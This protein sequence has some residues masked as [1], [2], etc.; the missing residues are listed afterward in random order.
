MDEKD[1]GYNTY[2]NTNTAGSN[3]VGVAEPTSRV[4]ENLSG[5]KDKVSEQAA[6]LKGKITDQAKT[7]GSQLTQKIDNARGKTSA[8]LRSTSD[9]IN[10]LAMYVE[11]HDARDM[12]EAVVKTSQELIRK[13]PGKS[14]V[15]GLVIGM[16]VGRIFTMGH[17]HHR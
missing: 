9:R 17:S 13:H 10:N 2:S 6:G 5:I 14:L 12:S 15:V 7:Y 4:K 1:Y 16:V 8:G 3:N 11:E